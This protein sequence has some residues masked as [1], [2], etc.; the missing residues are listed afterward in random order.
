MEQICL[1]NEMMLLKGRRGNLCLKLDISK[2]YE[3]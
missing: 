2:A 1:A 3:Y